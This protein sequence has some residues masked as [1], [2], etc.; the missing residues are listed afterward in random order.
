M[1]CGLRQARPGALRS[2]AAAAAAGME[3]AERCA[4]AHARHHCIGGLQACFRLQ[5]CVQKRLVR[6]FDKQHHVTIEA[7][8]DVKES[9]L[10]KAQRLART[11]RVARA[12][13]AP[14]N[15]LHA[16]VSWAADGRMN[17]ALRGWVSTYR[18]MTLS[19]TADFVV[20]S[21]IDSCR[22]AQL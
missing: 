22:C 6:L 3:A 14:G 10:R 12:H 8:A 11:Q 16:A 1:M 13:V 21:V 2:R 19:Y 7:R 5:G 9:S 20:A 18:A 15:V 4:A 17:L